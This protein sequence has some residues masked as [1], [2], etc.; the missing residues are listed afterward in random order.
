M[1][2]EIENQKHCISIAVELDLYY[3]IR[4]I[5]SDDRYDTE[6]KKSNKKEAIKNFI[7][8]YS[9][10]YNK[11]SEEEIKSIVRA[12]LEEMF[13]EQNNIEGQEER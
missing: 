9:K 8:N 7:K 4:S 12:K 11:I 6:T 5:E 13:C 2:D 1:V 10:T 3:I